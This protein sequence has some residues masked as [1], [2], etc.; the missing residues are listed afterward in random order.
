[1]F[2]KKVLYIGRTP[3]KNINIIYKIRNL[4]NDRKIEGQDGFFLSSLH[5]VF[6]VKQVKL[7]T[8]LE[9]KKFYQ[10]KFD[11]V[12]V[13]HKCGLDGKGV[14]YDDVKELKKL[15]MLKILTITNSQPENLPEEKILDLF[16]VI[17]KREIFKDRDLYNLS[18]SNKFKMHTTIISCPLIPVTISNIKS[19]DPKKFGYSEP[20]NFFD[21]DIF[22]SGSNTNIERINVLK[23]LYLKKFNVSFKLQ[24]KNNKD[25]IPT[26]MISK[27][28]S[29]KK[30]VNA[31]RNA[32][33]NL[34]LSGYGPF[35][36]R[37]LELMC[38]SC[39][40][41]ST[42]AIRKLELPFDYIE[43][44]HYITFDNFDDLNDKCL[45]YVSNETKRK[46]IAQNGRR[47][48]ESEYS[49]KK[50]GQ[51]INKIINQKLKF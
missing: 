46:E 34:A 28:F 39:F 5:Q 51:Y 24:P 12:F 18:N 23:Y 45:Y 14:L 31:A 50:H 37:H 43:N 2:K 40:S 32:K 35:T 16:D 49:F 42:P 8:L 44:T 13:N 26:K 48:F 29:Q 3:K 7:S 47:L 36:F 1:M 6:N 11:A 17:F 15:N 25:P 30:F 22:F 27:K 19:I 4:L 38:L 21:K 9:N 33:I 20:S 41:I 10:N